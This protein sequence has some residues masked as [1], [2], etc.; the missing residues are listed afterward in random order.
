MHGRECVNVQV[1]N[2]VKLQSHVEFTDR[3]EP[4]TK[5][6]TCGA[7]ILRR[8][9]VILDPSVLKHCSPFIFYGKT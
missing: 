7:P 9:Q 5:S 1:A 2:R 4:V 6:Y 3:P 8:S